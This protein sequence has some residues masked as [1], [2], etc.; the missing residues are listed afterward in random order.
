MIANS[1]RSGR[2]RK[3]QTTTGQDPDHR[4]SGITTLTL[5]VTVVIALPQSSA[6]ASR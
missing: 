2:H 4:N 1:G 6:D 3:S 5:T